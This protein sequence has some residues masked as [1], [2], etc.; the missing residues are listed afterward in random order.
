MFRS[1][2]SESNQKSARGDASGTVIGT[3]KEAIEIQIIRDSR[4]MHNQSQ[5]KLENNLSSQLR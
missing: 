5:T 4:T 1:G 3:S 2:G